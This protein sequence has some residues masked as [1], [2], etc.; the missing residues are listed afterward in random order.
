VGHGFC[1]RGLELRTGLSVPIG[2]LG[3]EY[4]DSAVGAPVG[5]GE[6]RGKCSVFNFL[7]YDY[8]IIEKFKN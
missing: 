4:A 1:A 6:R 3:A 2:D 8:K 7:E 5:G